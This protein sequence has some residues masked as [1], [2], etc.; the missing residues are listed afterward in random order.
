[1][2]VCSLVEIYH[3][4]ATHCLHLYCETETEGSSTMLAN[5]YHTTWCQTT[6]D[7]NHHSDT[8]RRTLNFM[9]L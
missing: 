2:M 9:K 6:E 7:G 5:F 4:T 1:M 3:F 8:A